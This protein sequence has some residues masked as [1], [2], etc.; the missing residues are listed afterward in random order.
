[1]GLSIKSTNPEPVWEKKKPAY[2]CFK[3][4]MDCLTTKQLSG[5]KA[6]ISPKAT[7]S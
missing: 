6:K 4:Y 3:L 1:M 7:S 2:Y 5:L